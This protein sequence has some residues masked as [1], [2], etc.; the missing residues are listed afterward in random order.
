[1]PE[2]RVRG[3]EPGIVDAQRRPGAAPAQDVL[4]GRTAQGCLFTSNQVEVGDKQRKVTR[5]PLR[6]TKPAT[7][8]LKA[9]VSARRGE[10]KQHH[11]KI[12]MDPSF[13]WDDEQGQKQK[14][15]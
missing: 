12:K 11:S 2:G 8:P 1:M 13:R 5:P 6:G 4:A 15:N 14:K 3:G 9:R 7:A 10:E